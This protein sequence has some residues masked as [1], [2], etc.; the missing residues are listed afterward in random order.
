MGIFS[1]IISGAANIFGAKSA[2]KEAARSTAKQIAFQRESAQKGYQWATADMKKAGIN[3]MLA[4]QQGGSSA[5]SGASYRPENVM[6]GAVSSALQARMQDQELENLKANMRKTNQDTNT[7]KAM[8]A[9]ATADAALKVNSARQMALQTQLLAT[10]LPQKKTFEA[11]DK[12]LFG[13]ASNWVGRLLQN[14]GLTGSSTSKNYRTNIG[15]GKR[16]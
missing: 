8:E 11:V 15:V 2:N 12:S 13:K 10:G 3:P 4:Y 7:G 16:R 5:L 6:S 1:S 14:S 9:A